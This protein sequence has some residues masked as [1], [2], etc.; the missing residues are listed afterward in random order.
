MITEFLPPVHTITT[1]EAVDLGL[2]SDFEVF[3]LKFFLDAVNKNIAGGT[4][5]KPK[6]TTEKA[7][8]SRVTKLMQ[9]AVMKK[10]DGMKFA[11]I[12]KRMQLLYNLPSKLRLAKLCLENMSKEPRRT[13]ILC[14]SIAQAN[15]LCEH[16]CH[17]ESGPEALERF[18]AGEID[19]IAAVKQ[20]NE[21]KNLHN[22]EQELIIQVDSQERNL[23]Q[24]IGRAVRKKLGR[25]DFKA[26]IVVLV[27]AN[28][29]DEKW[30]KSAI[31]EFNSTRI[32]E[33]I[34]RV[35]A[36]NKSTADAAV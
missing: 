7:E 25:P 21:G 34:V 19:I 29:A 30:Y 9:F 22:L 11:A 16:V 20:L 26:R 4:K 23:V 27:A 35:P 33:F 15:E 12:S 6:L 2:I 28:T 5:K 10:N 17:S 13:L 14:G 31:A 24:R 8:Y 32:K 36:V 18:Q 1:D 3:V